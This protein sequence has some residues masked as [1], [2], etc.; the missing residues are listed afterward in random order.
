MVD[1]H[2]HRLCWTESVEAK[3]HKCWALNDLKTL[4]ILHEREKENDLIILLTTAMACSFRHSFVCRHK[5][6]EIVAIE[7][8]TFIRHG[9]GIAPYNNK[10]CHIN[11]IADARLRCFHTVVQQAAAAAAAAVVWTLVFLVFSYFS[12]HNN[13]LHVPIQC[14][15]VIS[16][17]FGR[18][19]LCLV[20]TQP[21]RQ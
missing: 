16:H 7:E 3:S 11:K 12:W 14:I 6:F 2:L 1:C 4:S 9:D 19:G 13:F 20:R 17:L 5:T 8:A 15:D 18:R 21:T 10:V